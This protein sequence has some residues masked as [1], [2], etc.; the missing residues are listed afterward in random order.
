[1]RMLEQL[2]REPAVVRAQQAI[3]DLQ[4]QRDHVEISL[5]ADR[6]NRI[7]RNPDLAQKHLDRAAKTSVQREMRMTVVEGAVGL[8]AT[9]ACLACGSLDA[10]VY[11]AVGTCAGAVYVMPKVN[12][13]VD[14]RYILPR[15]TDA[16]LTQ[17]LEQNG[18]QL[19][20]M[21]EQSR[22]RKV[23]LETSLAEELLRRCEAQQTPVS[24]DRSSESVERREGALVIGGRV[25]IPIRG[26]VTS[27]A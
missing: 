18:Q 5:S 8:A 1:M 26:T 16:G 24:A 19:D 20:R 4:R 14:R 12:A 17:E 27:G 15:M 6:S 21:L 25:K 9:M 3:D 23:V 10:A 2:K 7:A 13:Y 11:L 22:A